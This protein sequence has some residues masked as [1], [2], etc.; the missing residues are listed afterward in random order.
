MNDVWL[1]DKLEPRSK[2]WG[3]LN[4]Q[5]YGPKNWVLAFNEGGKGI[6]WHMIWRVP[7]WWIHFHIY[8][9]GLVCD[10]GLKGTWCDGSG[11]L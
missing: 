7:P 2:W 10:V 1:G 6:V 4:H 8:V 3:K 5:K 11:R 9:Y